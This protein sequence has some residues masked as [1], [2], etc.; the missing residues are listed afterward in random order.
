MPHLWDDYC[1][2]VFNKRRLF[3]ITEAHLAEVTPEPPTEH[4]HIS[5]D[6]WSPLN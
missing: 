2:Q 6:I 4:V 1:V 5:F 3:P